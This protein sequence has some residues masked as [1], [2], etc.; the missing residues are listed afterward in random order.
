MTHVTELPISIF[1]EKRQMLYIYI[2]FGK[3]KR[4][5]KENLLV[6]FFQD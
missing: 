1:C 2:L 3:L 5:K 6:L 4:T